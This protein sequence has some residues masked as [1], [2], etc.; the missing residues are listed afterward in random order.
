M[1]KNISRFLYYIAIA[2]VIH[3]L[4]FFI[5]P[6][7]FLDAGERIE[8]LKSFRKYVTSVLWL[9]IFF[10]SILSFNFWVKF[11]LIGLALSFSLIFVYVGFAY[12]VPFSSGIVIDF[13]ESRFY[14]SELMN[15][16][17]LEAIGFIILSILFVLFITWSLNYKLD[18]DSF[19]LKKKTVI[20]FCVIC[21]VSIIFRT[22]RETVFPIRRIVE[23][24]T[25]MVTELPALK[26][27]MNQEEKPIE[28]KRNSK[29]TVPLTLLL[30]IGES[31]RYD[32]VK[33]NGYERDTMPN[34]TK[35][36]NEGNLISFKDAISFATCTRLSWLGIVTPATIKDP[37]VRAQ[38][39]I[40]SL[41]SQD[42]KTNCF[43]SSME[44][45]VR[46]TNTPTPLSALTVK[47]GYKCY[48]TDSA[49]V[50]Y[51]ELAKK[52]DENAQKDSF[53]VYYGEGSH[54]PYTNYDHSKYEIYKPV[55]NKVTKDQATINNYDNTLYATDDFIGKVI[56]K[57][58]DKNAVYIYVSDHAAFL[59]EN[60]RW[61]LTGKREM[62]FETSRRILFF[63]WFSEGF[64]ANFK[65]KYETFMANLEKLK[66]ISHD[67]VYHSILGAYDITNKYYNPK[68]DFFSSE[69]GPFTGKRPSELPNTA[70]LSEKE[71]LYQYE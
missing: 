59:G 52:I 8:S 40:P 30:H 14:A 45:T 54:V 65:D 31:A 5:L 25:Y 62:Y 11:F 57:L 36:F 69:C 27:I 1:K 24:F 55:S 64:K 46:N 66:P 56:Q 42:I 3:Y 48:L 2:V 63:V 9:S 70:T 18:K 34:L 21:F 71:L 29:Q 37:V 12:D 41:N 6:Y 61:T 49:M 4:L 23:P 32:H 13:V 17:N 22:V 58:S 44:K 10:V 7:D 51:P 60:D 28:T 68:L 19:F 53:Y 26:R 67:Y 35:Y 39:F 20:V 33:M 16:I 50:I 47:S 43:F 15:F 38:S